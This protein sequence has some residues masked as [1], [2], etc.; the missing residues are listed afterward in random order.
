MDSL[1]RSSLLDTIN[2][3]KDSDYVTTVIIG[4]DSYGMPELS[5]QLN[6][7]IKCVSKCCHSFIVFPAFSR[8]IS[9]FFSR[10]D[11]I[12]NPLLSI[13]QIDISD[14]GYFL[15]DSGEWTTAWNYAVGENAAK[16]AITPAFQSAITR[17]LQHPG[18]M[19]VHFQVSEETPLY[20]ID[21]AIDYVFKLPDFD[22]MTLHFA[23]TIEEDFYNQTIVSVM[24]GDFQEKL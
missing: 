12:F 19:L 22:E 24:A 13:I 18:K 21:E 15:R 8:S 5:Y 9:D 3:C 17:G 2:H 4:D 6:D 16:I 14:L 11:N 23:V 10:L 1:T 20:H 7:Y